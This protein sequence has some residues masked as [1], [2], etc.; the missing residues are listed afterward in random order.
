M[1]YSCTIHVVPEQRTSPAKVA[2]PYGKSVE[3]TCISEVEVKWYFEDEELP[4]NT[5]LH[6]AVPPETAHRLLI[7]NLDQRSHGSYKCVSRIS[8]DDKYAYFYSESVVMLKGSTC[9]FC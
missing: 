1:S 9:I 3:L 4:K 8:A 2:L 7:L 6:P 5:R